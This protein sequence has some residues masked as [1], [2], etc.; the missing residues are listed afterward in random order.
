MVDIAGIWIVV[1]G[2]GLACSARLSSSR[3]I[4]L[5]EYPGEFEGQR[6]SGEFEGFPLIGRLF[7]LRRFL[8]TGG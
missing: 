6:P 3:E 1:K 5:P 4:S 7:R 8:L 2:D